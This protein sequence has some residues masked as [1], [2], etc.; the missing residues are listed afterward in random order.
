M[1]PFVA[2]VE[3][4]RPELL[5]FVG[6]RQGQS[7]VLWGAKE[8]G[9]LICT[10]GGRH[11][12][13]V[14]Y[15]DH[16]LSDGSWVYFGQGQSGDQKM[17]NAANSKLA[18][19]D[20]SVLLFTT[21]EPTS[22]E[23]AAQGNYGKRYF[24]QGSFNV[25]SIDEVVVVDGPRMGDRLLCFRLVPAADSISIESPSLAMDLE[26]LPRVQLELAAGAGSVIS[27]RLSDVEY[28]L[29]SRAIQQYALARSRGFCE[30]CLRPAPFAKSDGAPFLEV[31]H[32]TRL[33][34]EGPDVPA[35]VAAV[36]PNCHRAAHYASNRSE[37]GERLR[38]YV[39]EAE[40]E[41]T[42]LGGRTRMIL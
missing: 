27:K 5:D 41:I 10:S 19:G 34:D 8:S 13:K 33:A 12:K 26:D 21:R 42:Q 28:R 37:L 25:V 29:R 15:S 31:H 9:C 35:N 39:L 2:G 16:S 4:R 23:V 38:A 1:H 3:Y 36:C 24:F 32:L 20:R 30:A 22:R 6:S 40:E 11:G 14:G 18:A 7:G 17:T